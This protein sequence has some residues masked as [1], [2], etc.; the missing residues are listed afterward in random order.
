ML[1]D[2][3]L[4]QQFLAV[5]AVGKYQIVVFLLF[6]HLLR[7]LLSILLF[8][9]LP[10]PLP[11]TPRQPE[12]APHHSYHPFHILLIRTDDFVDVHFLLLDKV[13]SVVGTGL[14][15]VCNFVAV[16]AAVEVKYELLPGKDV[17][18]VERTA[19]LLLLFLLFEHSNIIIPA[20]VKSDRSSVH[21]LTK[22]IKVIHRSFIK[23]GMCYWQ[24][25]H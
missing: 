15:E 18:G 2:F 20:N 14:E 4:L 25:L 16:L 13:Q 23:T 22:H 3:Y 6:F 9:L 12:I 1:L 5:F 7:L 8:G 21:M 24:L 11:L 10:T 19:G 17:V